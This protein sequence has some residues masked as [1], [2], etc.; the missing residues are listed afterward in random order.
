MA[1]VAALIGAGFVAAAR[2]FRD[3]FPHEAPPAV[4][5]GLG[6]FAAAAIAA[7]SSGLVFALDGG[8][9]TVS[10]ALAALASAFVADRLELMPLRWCVAALGLV[11]AGRLAY[12]PRIV[13]S[14]L[15]PTPIFNWLLFGY[16]VPA[17]AF[18]YAGRL[19]RRQ[20][21]D[22]P[23]RAAD[24]LAVLFA[25]FL[26]FFEIRHAMNGGDPYAPASGLVE[27]GLMSV[28]AFG[29]AF[30]LTRL[31]AMHANVVFRWASLAAGA[32]GL[33]GAC[34]GLLLFVNPFF[35]GTP[36]EGGLVIN[37][38]LI[39]YLLPAG[40]SCAV[41]VY[42]RG[43]RPLWYWGGAGVLSAALGL[44]YL[45]LQMRVIFHGADISW[46]QTFTLGETGVVICILLLCAL[47]PTVL[48]PRAAPVLLATKILAG[49]ALASAAIGLGVRV[50]PVVGGESI[51]GG[52]FLN[53]LLLSY[54]A[55]AALCA[56]LANFLR[57]LLRI[58]LAQAL[59]IAAILLVFAYA[60]LETRRAFQ[61]PA[62]RW[63]LP[64]SDAEYYVYSAV[65]LLLGLAL[66]A[67]GV[68]RKSKE[69][70][71]ASAFFIIV[72]TVKVFVFDLASLEGA[73]RALSFL[74][75]GVALIGIGLVYQRVVFVRARPQ[76]P[77]S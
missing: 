7:L 22:I 54:A 14:A 75:L 36:V 62:I 27:Q 41:A 63:D 61:G 25:A 34:L 57:R 51:G 20:A 6:A 73:L 77:Q 66:L 30:A 15:S 9:L 24:A 38:L 17:A 53:V 8:A 28:S 69:A 43:R 1:L 19:L 32:L 64:T 71:W 21:D 74:G 56:A 44:T 31:D 5:I 48:F 55:P 72:T 58:S 4:R 76:T 26:V 35:S 18:G 46:E 40:L 42:A 3:G 50:N 33:A 59:S 68:W 16:G 70:R 29:F 65:W 52:A 45:L 60:T 11:I 10:L 47:V 37:A 2:L 13:G 49:A 39:G 23:A 12:E 67:Y